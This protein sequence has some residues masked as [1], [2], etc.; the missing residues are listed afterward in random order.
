MRLRYIYSISK[1]QLSFHSSRGHSNVV[2]YHV[3]AKL[4]VHTYRRLCRATNINTRP[5]V[6]SPL[7]QWCW[8]QAVVCL[9]THR[10][11]PQNRYFFNQL[12]NNISSV[13]YLNFSTMQTFLEKHFSTTTALHYIA[14]LRKHY[15]LGCLE[16]QTWKRDVNSEKVKMSFPSA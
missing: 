9:S 16:H 12:Y 6:S 13:I 15:V 4:C 1:Q 7:Q 10:M 5:R 2:N 14:S 3:E 11:Y 8:S